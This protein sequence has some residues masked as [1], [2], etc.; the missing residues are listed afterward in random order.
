M[1][2][3]ARAAAAHRMRTHFGGP[4]Q[5]FAGLET[6]LAAALATLERTAQLDNAAPVPTVADAAGGGGGGGD[7]QADSAAGSGAPSADASSEQDGDARP[8]LSQRGGDPAAEAPGGS[9][10]DDGGAAPAAK[11]KVLSRG[12][13]TSAAGGQRR[14]PAALAPRARQ[15]LARAG[16]PARAASTRDGGGAGAGTGGGGRSGGGGR[17]DA[18]AQEAAAAAVAAP[19]AETLPAVRC[20]VALLLEFLAALERFLHAAFEGS[21]DRRPPPATATAFFLQNR[22]VRQPRRNTVA[23]QGRSAAYFG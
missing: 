6:A 1:Q 18:Q 19:S 22:K 9:G 3:G 8:Q 7:S 17:I 15:F 13:Q 20:R 11:L 14:A 2:Q 5:T 21:L 4:T 12:L 23:L 16:V 10:A